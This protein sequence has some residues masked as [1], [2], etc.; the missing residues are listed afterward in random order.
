MLFNLQWL[1]L[2]NC[3]TQNYCMEDTGN[4]ANAE[5]TRIQTVAAKK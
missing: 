3:S 5:V 2:S 1:N 4:D